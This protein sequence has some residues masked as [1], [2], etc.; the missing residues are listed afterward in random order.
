MTSIIVCETSIKNIYYK[1]EILNVQ[2]KH[3]KNPTILKKN[4]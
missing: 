2:N 1:I 4:N 3:K